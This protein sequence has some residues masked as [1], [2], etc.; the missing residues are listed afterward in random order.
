MTLMPHLKW[1][2][3]KKILTTALVGRNKQYA[4]NKDNTLTK[5]YLTLVE[6]I[7]T[8]KY[9][10]ENFLFKKLAEQIINVKAVNPFIL[11]GSHA[12]SYA[13]QES[14]VDLFCIENC[15]KNKSAT[16]SNLKPPMAKPS[17]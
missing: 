12:K 14:D 6:E 3:E 2:E 11:F 8:I 9:L 5:Y 15:L 16:L 13:T 1:L 17:T 7:A 4:L 10:E